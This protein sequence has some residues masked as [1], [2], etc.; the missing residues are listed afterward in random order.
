MIEEL[1]GVKQITEALEDL[2][3]AFNFKPA[4]AAVSC[5]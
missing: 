1:K 2:K 4:A 3:I 5:L